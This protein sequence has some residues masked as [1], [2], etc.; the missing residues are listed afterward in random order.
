MK[1][2]RF[3]KPI[4]VLCVIA[5]AFQLFNGVVLAQ[6][7]PGNTFTKPATKPPAAPPDEKKFFHLR[8]VQSIPQ[9]KPFDVRAQPQLN[10]PATPAQASTKTDFG[11]TGG[12]D[13]QSNWY[14]T[15]SFGNFT[16]YYNDL[17]YYQLLY[18]TQPQYM[19]QDINNLGLGWMCLAPG[20]CEALGGG[21]AASASA[22]PQDQPQL[23]DLPIL[24]G[25]GGATGNWNQFEGA[26][27][28]PDIL[29][30]DP[31]NPLASG[32]GSSTM[33]APLNVQAILGYDPFAGNRFGT[34][35]QA[36]LKSLNTPW[37]FYSPWLSD[38]GFGQGSAAY[39]AGFKDLSQKQLDAVYASPQLQALRS[40][41]TYT[42]LY[43]LYSDPAYV[44]WDYVLNDY[45]TQ[46]YTSRPS[47]AQ[48]YKLLTTINSWNDVS[49]DSTLLE[50]RY[51]V[52]LLANYWQAYVEYEVQAYLQ[53]NAEAQQWVDQARSFL[54]KRRTLLYQAAKLDTWANDW[55]TRWANSYQQAVNNSNVAQTAQQFLTETPALAEY[56]Q[57]NHDVVQLLPEF[58]DHPVA[59]Q[60]QTERLQTIDDA[61]VASQISDAYQKYTNVLQQQLGNTAFVAETEHFNEQLNVAVTKETTYQ[62]LLQTTQTIAGNF[63]TYQQQV[64]QFI[65]QCYPNSGDQC[66]VDSRLL[67]YTQGKDVASMIVSIGNLYEN[68]RLF[69]YTFYRSDAYKQI[70]N[71]STSSMNQTLAPVKDTIN[72]AR[73]AFIGDVNKIDPVKQLRLDSVNA[74]QTLRGHSN[75]VI[76]ASVLAQY[77]KASAEL[78]QKLTRMS[79]LV[80]QLRGAST[81]LP[82]PTNNQTIYLPVIQR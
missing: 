16:N 38:S 41:Y 44:Y 36:N 12:Y 73:R 34:E 56:L 72:T 28:F 20:L 13:W 71:A 55:Q 21:F 4:C 40:E 43:V 8:P 32:A 6:A 10:I 29:G 2:V 74:L 31:A 58:K 82:N 49:E 15:F 57:L 42:P 47:Y 3:A 75:G 65:Q 14:S 9:P 30:V 79:Q 35:Y 46:I 50:S 81:P 45:L 7:L 62:Q 11:W 27:P 26:Q 77:Q 25:I 63:S 33:Q 5:L 80:S 76:S 53:Q 67:N 66:Y 17:R 70:E 61:T 54:E 78:D 39:E 48:L 68:Y 51:I 18:A 37:V 59:T 69:W 23:F 52:R 19:L 24:N 60:L 1:R 64:Y 22:T